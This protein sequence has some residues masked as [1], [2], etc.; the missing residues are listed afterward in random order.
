M[1]KFEVLSSETVYY[2]TVIEAENSE[3]AIKKV[4]DFGVGEDDA[5]DSEFW[6]IDGVYSLE[7][8]ENA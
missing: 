8:K 7:D 1:P 5:V 2:T 6:K 3:D 4:Y